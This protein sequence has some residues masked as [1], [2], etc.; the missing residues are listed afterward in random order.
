M[1][2][3]AGTG[4]DRVAD[5]YDATRGG[6]ARARTEASDLAPHVV[7]GDVLEVRVGTG[8][9]ARALLDGV[10]AVR[11]LAGV[12]VSAGMLAVARGRLPGALVR[13]SA[14]PLLFAAA[15]FDDVVAVHVLHLVPD[16]AATEPLRRLRG[17]RP[18]EPDDV[19]R[20]AAA[21]GLRL[22]TRRP[23]A[24]QRAAHSPAGLADLVERRTWSYLW[25]VDA[26]TWDGTVAPVVDALRGLPDPDRPS[27]RRRG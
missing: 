5:R 7:P 3:G 11:R 27:P 23:S 4:F 14:V 20:A 26:A 19:D 1:P 25:S 17:P 10:P 6:D 18:D 24:P 21:A 9:V 13:G 16:P 2:D 22:V 15:S 12:D 8:L